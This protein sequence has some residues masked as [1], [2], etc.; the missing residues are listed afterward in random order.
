MIRG[1]FR[2]I[3][4]II[5]LLLWLP[6]VGLRTVFALRGKTP[7]ER[8]QTASL[9]TIQW[10][11]GIRDI[12]NVHTHIHGNLPESKGVLLVS[13]HL[14]Y[15]DIVVHASFMGVRFAPKK[16]IRTWPIL[17][18]Y[19][20]LSQPVWIDR[21]NRS[22]SQETLLEFEKTLEL[23]VPL[24]VYP[25]GT[26]TDGLHGLLPFKST[27]FEAAIKNNRP[28]QPMITL[29]KVPEGSMNPAW[30]GDQ[31]LLPHVWELLGIREFQADIYLLPPVYPNQYANRKELAEAVREKMLAVYQKVMEERK[32]N[33]K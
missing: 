16:E 1:F 25:E 33:A 14:G 26:S 4:R 18:P 12:M 5:R 31:E 10:A 20:G 22:K 2:K 9:Y 29:Y 15:L 30:F 23:E 6:D 19:L 3:F 7:D 32:D 11:A 17:G 21:K 13:N 8:I 24:I 27:P 28:I